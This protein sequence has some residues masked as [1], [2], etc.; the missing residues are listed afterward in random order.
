MSDEFVN[1]VTLEYLLNK[2]MYSSQIK[3]KKK[4]TLSKE[5]TTVYHKRIYNLFKDILEGTP[6]DNLFLDVI[7]TYDTFVGSAINY[8]KVLDKSDIIQAEHMNSI[9]DINDN[10]LDCSTNDMSDLNSSLF[11][12]RS[13]KMDVPTLDKYVTRTSVKKK[14]EIIHPQQKDVNLQT[15]E[16]KI[17]VLKK[18]NITNKYEDKGKT[19]ETQKE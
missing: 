6:P 8:F 16:L 2:E 17:N 15:T 12:M 19:E 1:R 18:N 3:R 5:D 14:T 13:I 9:N 10:K 11:A 4:D 7:S